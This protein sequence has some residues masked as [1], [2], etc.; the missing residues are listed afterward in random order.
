MEKKTQ[1]CYGSIDGLRDDGKILFQ[2]EI[3]KP[4]SSSSNNEFVMV[5]K[6][7]ENMLHT[8]ENS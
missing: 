5:Y 6:S 3:R 4:S 2:W 1:N 7:L 8:S